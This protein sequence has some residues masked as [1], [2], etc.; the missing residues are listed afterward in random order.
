MSI[1]AAKSVLPTECFDPVTLPCQASSVIRGEAYV[2]TFNLRML[3]FSGGAALV[4]ATD[5]KNEVRCSVNSD[6]I[7]SYSKN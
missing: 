1:S 5:I 2:C 7:L 6:A 4:N 3:I